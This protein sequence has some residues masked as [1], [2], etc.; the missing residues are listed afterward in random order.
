MGL[1]LALG[2]FLAGLII[3]AS[4]YAHETLAR[5]LSLRDAFVALFFVTIGILIDPRIIVENLALL[6]AMIGLIVA[7]KFLIRAGI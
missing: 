7:G 1:S 5:L 6:A 2:A 4:E 3:S